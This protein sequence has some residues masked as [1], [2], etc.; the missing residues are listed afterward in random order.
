MPGHTCHWPGCK[1]QVP[2]AR[3]GCRD[4][5]YRLPKA[6][7]DRIWR[8]YRPGQEVDK[9]PSQDYLNAARAVQD[10]IRTVQP[11]VKPFQPSIH[12]ST[13]PKENRR[14]PEDPTP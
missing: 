4:H 3:W 5:W 13:L 11:E 14:A 2:P 7:R 6:L 8:S 9:R 12:R 1:Q 10:W